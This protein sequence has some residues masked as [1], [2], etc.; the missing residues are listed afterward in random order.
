M[1][2]DYRARHSLVVT[3]SQGRH[4]GCSGA[5]K[6]TLVYYN[7]LTPPDKDGVEPRGR[8]P[9]KG[10]GMANKNPR[11]LKIK[12]GPAGS[13]AHVGSR[14]KG[15][16]PISTTMDAGTL[17]GVTCT[18]GKGKKTGDS[19]PA[20]D[21]QPWYGVT[22]AEHSESSP[23]VIP[24]TEGKFGDSYHL[25]MSTQQRSRG[26]VVSRDPGLVQ[27]PTPQF[28]AILSESRPH[29]ADSYYARIDKA[30]REHRANVAQLRL[31]DFGGKESGNET[32]ETQDGAGRERGNEI[33]DGGHCAAENS[34]S[35]S[36]S[37]G[38]QQSPELDKSVSKQ[39]AAKSKF[40]I[41]L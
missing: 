6:N 31:H 10:L 20:R 5:V 16:N 14:A 23:S 7:P 22:L 32:Q 24:M 21:V 30:F 25:H 1:P 3:D 18:G 17:H 26:H 9:N 2:E 28:P 4:I 8:K 36:N 13:V 27:E 37:T 41:I 34:V 11:T 35:L 39:T 15:K 29:S 33:Q 38:S 40:C 19:G 12:V